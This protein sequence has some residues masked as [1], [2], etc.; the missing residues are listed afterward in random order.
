MVHYARG[1]SALPLP[2]MVRQ[3]GPLFA[4]LVLL[5]ATGCV[6]RR[7]TIRSDPPGA[8]VEV[9][10]ERLGFTPVSFDFDYFATRE[11][12]LS[13]A[14]YETLTVLQPIK[15]PWYEIPPLDAVSDNLLPYRVTNRHDFAY[16]L[17]RQRV[18][19]T[20]ELIDR[21]SDIRSRVR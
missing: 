19:S 16:K 18:E 12:T 15:A 17:T 9:D 5:A 21:A 6:S 10:G 14:G 13:K 8:L 20:P 3:A 4:A 1:V 2:P 7:V 11:I